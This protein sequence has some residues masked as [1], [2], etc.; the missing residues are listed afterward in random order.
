MLSQSFGNS[1]AEGLK[2]Q[3]LAAK[4]AAVR[5]FATPRRLALLVPNVKAGAGDSTKEVDGPPV[6]A[7]PEAV[8]GFARKQGI[9]PASLQQRDGPKGKIYFAKVE[10]KGATLEA[11]LAGI[12]ADAVKKLPIPKVMRWGS[13]DA[14]FV[15]PVHGLVMLH[16]A[17][18]VPGTVLGLASGNRT[19]G[20]RFMGAGDIALANAEE[21]EQ[22]LLAGHVVADFEKRKSEIDTLLQAEAKKQNASLGEYSALLDEVAAL[23]EHPSVYVGEFDKA[24]L[25][26]PQ[27]CLI[28]TMRQNQKYFPAVRRGRQAD[29]QVPDRVAT[30]RSPIRATSSAATSAWCA[31][32]WKTRAFST[33]RTASKAWKSASRCSPRSSITTSSAA[34]ST[35]CSA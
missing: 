28:L 14:Q 6:S 31:R 35:A 27:E 21:Y 34:S 23:V 26:V 18:V 7:K 3:G 15:R 11:A 32:V 1:V 25:E 13:G 30:C 22:K 8:A 10:V 20:H 17:H 29:R 4:D 24:F 9:D 5:M 16:G 33:T 12:V 2:A 19:R